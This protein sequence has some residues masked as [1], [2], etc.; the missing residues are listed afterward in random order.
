MGMWLFKFDQPRGFDAMRFETEDFTRIASH[1]RV[2]VDP[3]DR[4]VIYNIAEKHVA[5]VV[6]VTE[7]AT[8]QS[9]G[10]DLD[11]WPYAFG[12]RPELLSS[13]GPKRSVPGRNFRRLEGDE[14]AELE[15]VVRLNRD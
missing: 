10:E 7:P 13:R 11:R 12:T 14:F 2:S 4:V 6:R 15:A 5:A 1:V 9:E 8:K 3:G